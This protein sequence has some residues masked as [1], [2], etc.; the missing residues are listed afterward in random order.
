MNGKFL[1]EFRNLG[2]LEHFFSWRYCRFYDI[3]V[4]GILLLLASLPSFSPSKKLILY[5]QILCRWGSIIKGGMH[6]KS[7]VFAHFNAAKFQAP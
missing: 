6:S 4:C 5:R 2:R 3:L 1:Y 7:Q